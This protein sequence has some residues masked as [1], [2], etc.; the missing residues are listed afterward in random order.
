MLPIG[1]RRAGALSPLTTCLALILLLTSTASAAVLGIDFGTLNIKAA[2]IKPGIP[3][4]I[5][6]TKDSKRKEVAAVAF[7]P[8]K[9]EKGNIVAKLGQFPERAYGSDALALQGR[10]PG[11]VFPNLKLLLGTQIGPEADKTSRIYRQRY[12][13]VQL[14]QVKELGTTV[15]KS[16]AFTDEVLPFSVEELI[17]MELANIKKNA[18]LMAGKGSSVDDVVITVPPFYTADEKQAIIKAATFAGF[19]VNA[20]ISDGLAVGLD[21]AKTRSFPEVTKGEKP[22]YHMVFD[23]G[24]G[25]TSATVMRFQSKSVKDVGRF[26]KT[27]QE[28]AVVGAGWERLLGGDSLTQLITDDLVKKLLTK[29]VLK[30]R[31]TTEDEIKKNPRLMARLFKEAERARQVLSANT[32]TGISMEEIL[33]DIDFR[34]KLT[35]S[36]FEKLASGFD[37]RVEHPIKEALKMAKLEIGDVKSVILHGGAIRTPF[38]QSKLEDV[39]GDAAK[40]RSNVNPDE[41]AVFG[42]AFKAA[43]L[44]AS[45][46]VKEIRDSDI[47]GYATGLTFMDQDKERKKSLFG[48][49]APVGAGSTTKQVSFK[50]KEDFAFGFVQNVDGVDRSIVRVKSENLT[51]SVEELQRRAGCDKESINTKFNV[52][53]APQHG[54]PDVTGGSVSCEVDPSAKSGSLGDSV[55]GWLGFGKNKEQEALGEEDDGPVEQVDAT[56]SASASG[57]ASSASGTSSSGTSTKSAEPTK[58]VEVIPL[59]WSTSPEGNPQPA[60]EAIKAMIDR[61]KAFDESDKSRFARDEAQ[62]ALESYTYFVRDFLENKDYEAA[63]TKEERELIAN[64]LQSTRDWME[65]GDLAKASKETLKEKHEALKKLVEPIRKRKTESDKRPEVIDGMKKT[66]DELQKGILRIESESAKAAASLASA[67]TA[68]ESSTTSEPTES[69]TADPDDLEE[70]ETT[71]KAAPKSSAAPTNPYDSIDLV[72]IQEIY[73]SVSTWFT[74][75]LAEQ[76]K[77]KPYEDPVLLVKEIEKKSNEIQQ[78]L[79]DLVEKAAKASKP[80]ATKKPKTTKSKTAKKAQ[81][82]ADDTDEPVPAEPVPEDTSSDDIPVAPADPEAEQVPLSDE[83][84]KPA[85]GKKQ[86]KPKKPVKG[87]ESME[88]MMK[89]MKEN[90]VKVAEPGDDEA[91]PGGKRDEL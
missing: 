38:V 39:V 85:K 37:E 60:A 7:K 24:A 67:A 2:I 55:K 30:S 70:P 15:F 86:K 3:L 9:D 5:V 91:K 88:D 79:Q 49:N 87:G 19:E 47:A 54:L 68:S 46:K 26:N 28:V 11:E 76:D 27:V 13:G 14:E 83:E 78:S 23:M 43:A 21:Y 52:R 69:S 1:R 40:L 4:D 12:P 45:F 72:G 18:Q 59:R 66:L 34:T 80:K 81:A 56:P 65:S 44:S 58:S 41:S 25:S 61:L 42:A 51:S 90:N 48:P 84:E 22:E 35:R 64:N 6:L 36:E 53:L 75:K 63:S 77:L 33:P 71:T 50:D 62:N 74:E 29:P 89:W 82:T 57:E 73:T 16:Q 20:L 17:A 32:E 8:T 10:F 31:G